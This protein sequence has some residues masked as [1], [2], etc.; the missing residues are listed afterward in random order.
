MR[1]FIFAFILFGSVLPSFA[2]T[3]KTDTLRHIRLTSLSFDISYYELS[4]DSTICIVDTVYR[5]SMMLFSDANNPDTQFVSNIIDC[6]FSK[7][8]A[9][10]GKDVSTAD[11]FFVKYT[12]QVLLEDY[13][14][15]S[16]LY[17]PSIFN[18][19]YYKPLEINLV[20]LI[21]ILFNE[22]HLAEIKGCCDKK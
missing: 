19:K 16:R 3:Q 13:Q 12:C 9:N 8:W 6:I 14:T 20:L 7:S 18:S 4:R 5:S 22:F 10:V 2:Q 15:G 21:Q 17:I 11:S 1:R